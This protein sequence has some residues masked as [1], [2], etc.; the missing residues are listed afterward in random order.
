MENISLLKKQFTCVNCDFITFNKKDYKRHLQTEKHIKQIEIF[1]TFYPVRF[2]KIRHIK[3]S[4]TCEIGKEKKCIKT[5]E[6]KFKPPLSQDI[7]ICTCSKQY[8]TASGLWKHKK[9]C[10]FVTCTANDNS[11]KTKETTPKFDEHMLSAYMTII[12]Q[13]QEIKNLMIKNQEFQTQILELFKEGRNNNEKLS[14]S[15]LCN[16]LNSISI[17]CALEEFVNL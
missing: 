1:G 15:D 2:K 3:Y 14:A 17:G 5:K 6:T 11:D 4:N 13:N 7:H 8:K 12:K 10:E 16:S 9:T